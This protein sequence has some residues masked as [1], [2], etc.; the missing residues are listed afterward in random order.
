MLKSLFKKPA[1]KVVKFNSEQEVID[2]FA[3]KPKK[4]T[5]VKMQKPLNI[6]HS[7]IPEKSILDFT[8]KEWFDYVTTHFPHKLKTVKNYETSKNV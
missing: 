5:L 1:K 2:F 3:Y 8:E 7:I 6:S 4:D